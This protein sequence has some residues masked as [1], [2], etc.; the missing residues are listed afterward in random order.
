MFIG[1]GI[2]I[3]VMAT[4][5][6]PPAPTYPWVDGDTIRSGTA[7]FAPTDSIRGGTATFQPTDS[8]RGTT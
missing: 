7:T 1:I 5:A 4:P 8:I 3:G 2:Q 6:A